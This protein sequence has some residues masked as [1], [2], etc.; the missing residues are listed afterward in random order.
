MTYL[1][2]PQ[3]AQVVL[4]ETLAPGQTVI[5]ITAPA[6]ACVGVTVG[7]VLHGAGPA[8]E[9]G[10]AS[11]PLEALPASGTARVVV[12]GANLVPKVVDLPIGAASIAD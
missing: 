12:T 4:P 7:G 1:G 9:D 5:E 10:R 2:A 11:I 3:E 6:R 8:G